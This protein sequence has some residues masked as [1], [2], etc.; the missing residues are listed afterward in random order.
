MPQ[1]ISHPLKH[2][3]DHWH[4]VTSLRYN[5]FLQAITALE[6]DDA[7][8]HLSVFSTLLRNILDFSDRRLH[9]LIDESDQ[10]YELIKADLLILTKTL[11]K[12]EDGV[13][14]LQ[15]I[16]KCQPNDLRAELVDRLDLLVRLNNI[17]N[18]HQIRQVELLFP[19][20]E[21][22]VLGQRATSLANEMTQV[23]QRALPN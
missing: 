21:K 18:K 5:Q 16:E 10:S 7:A 14:D 20:F 13:A 8:R 4:G 23:M 22:K 6:L 19:L 17:L 11:V 2:E 1:D 15:K 9:E 12:V 3:Y